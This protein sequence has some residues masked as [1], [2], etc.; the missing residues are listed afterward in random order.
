LTGYWGVAINLNYGGFTNGIGGGN[1]GRSY[2][3]GY[4]A[5]TDKYEIINT[6]MPD[7]KTT[8]NI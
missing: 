7:G 1:N 2:E 3:P 6:V 8:N 5:F 4:S